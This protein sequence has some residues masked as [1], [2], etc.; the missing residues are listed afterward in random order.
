MHVPKSYWVEA[1]LMIANIINR[2]PLKTLNFET[3]SG[4][5]GG[6]C[7]FIVPFKVFGGV[8]YS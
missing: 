8:I 6:K 2:L 7:S 5:L 4:L 1:V 3:P